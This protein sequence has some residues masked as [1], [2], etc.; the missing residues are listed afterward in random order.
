MNRREF[1]TTSSSAA[2][3]LGLSGC[4][5]L[6]TGKAYIKPE[7]T[8]FEPEK[9]L[10]KPIGT[11][12][13]GEIG[14]TGIK[15]SKFG[16]GSHMNKD[17]VKYTKEREWMVRE[18]F[19][20]GV[21]LFDVYDYEFGIY[22]Y[23]PM[24]RY[25]KDVIH[26]VV[27]SITTWP[28]DGRTVKQQM[29][30]DLRLFGRD[31]IDLVRIH[32][33]KNTQ[34]EQELKEQVGHRWEW[35][36]TL[37]RMKEK[38]YIRAVGV[39]VHT[40][41]DLVQPLAEL[42][43]DFVI[44]PYNFYHNWSFSGKKPTEWDAVIKEL[45]RK[46]TGIISMKPFAGDHLVTPFKRLAGRYDD[47]GEIS[48]AQA[49]LRYVLNSGMNFDATLGGMY[50]PYHVH[51]NVDA[52]FHPAMSAEEGEILKRVR[53]TVKGIAKNLLP[54]HYKFLEQWA[55]DVYDDADPDSIV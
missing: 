15:V 47:T 43:I 30:R 45:R 18:A 27:I 4:S 53:T 32:A 34:D 3:G 26:D 42:P 40:R 29:E 2:I 14:K 38:G 5:S 19:D 22:Q 13:A 28:F 36:E 44:V 24:G 25:L 48:F 16:F 50:S 20:L 35:W 46:G 11:M 10:T 51:E 52:F 39:P 7:Q 31:Y 49:C 54:D 17:I 33:W 1:L 9:K 6:G 55:P 37:F 21:T 41:E 8:P 23:E 12:P